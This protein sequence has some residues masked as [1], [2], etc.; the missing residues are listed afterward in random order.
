MLGTKQEPQKLVM[1][2]QVAV[3]NQQEL[4]AAVQRSLEAAVYGGMA[5]DK[6]NFGM[7]SF[8]KVHYPLL[9]LGQ[10]QTPFKL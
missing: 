6:V 4:S 9:P 7:C 1:P 10:V 2:A 8:T 3:Q 5:V